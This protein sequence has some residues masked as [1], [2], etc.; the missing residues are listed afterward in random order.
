MIIILGFVAFSESPA[1]F[2]FGHQ[3]IHLISS[4]QSLSLSYSGADPAR[5]I[6]YLLGHSTVR[7]LISDGPREP[8]VTSLVV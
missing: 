4:S 5:R 2:L 8:P 3:S 1:C 6:D 7:R